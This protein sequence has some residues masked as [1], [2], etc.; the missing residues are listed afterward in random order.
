MAPMIAMT[1][2]AAPQPIMSFL[3]KNIRP[4]LP[5]AARHPAHIYP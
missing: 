5:S 4:F 3:V 1:T 2:M